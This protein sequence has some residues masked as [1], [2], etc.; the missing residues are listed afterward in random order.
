MES[1]GK[2][3]SEL[4]NTH[5][6]K[7]P[8]KGKPAADQWTVLSAIVMEHSGK[9]TVVTM[10]TGT[11]CVGE[12]QKSPT[13]V[14]D[15]HGEVL[16]LRLFRLF[17]LEDMMRCL[18]SE[19]GICLE[20][21]SGRQFV[22][23]EGVSFHFY[24]SHVMCGD[25]TISQTVPSSAEDKKCP[26]S[27]T[28]SLCP[29]PDNQS[30]F[31]PPDNQS[32]CPPPD[33]QSVCDKKRPSSPSYT[34]QTKHV[35]LDTTSRTGAKCLLLDNLQSETLR[36]RSWGKTS[37][38]RTKPGRG[39]VCLSLS[40]S[41]KL[42]KRQFL[43]LQGG[44]LS[45]FLRCP[46][47]FSTF[48]IGGDFCVD[49]VKRALFDRIPDSTVVQPPIFKVEDIFV[50]SVNNI[51]SN[52]KDKDILSSSSSIL[53]IKRGEDCQHWASVK[54]KVQGAT[55]SSS[56]TKTMLPVCRTAM[57]GKALFV[58]SLLDNEYR[59][60]SSG[61]AC[62]VSF[63]DSFISNKGDNFG[64][65]YQLFKS[66]SWVMAME[67]WEA[68]IIS[69]TILL[70][71]TVV[72]GFVPRALKV[73][74]N[75]KYISIANCVA[76]GV[77]MGTSLLHLLPEVMEDVTEGLKQNDIDTD[78]PIATLTVGLG[79]L[80][81]VFVEMLAH[82]IQDWMATRDEVRTVA[83]NANPTPEQEEMHIP[84]SFV[85]DE[86]NIFDSMERV[87]RF[88]RA[89]SRGKLENRNRVKTARKYSDPEKKPLLN[90]S[91]QNARRGANL[92]VNPEE[93]AGNSHGHSHG[94]SH[95]HDGHT[96]HAHGHGHGPGHAHDH[97]P[98][99][100]FKGFGSIL[101][102]F[103]L[104]V[105]SILEGM[106]VGSEK[107]WLMVFTLTGALSLHKALLAFALGCKIVEESQSL[108]THIRSVAF[109]ACSSP[110]GVAIGV[111]VELSHSDM[112]VKTLVEGLIQAI[113]T[114]TFLYIAFVEIVTP[115]L[116][117]PD[118]PPLLKVL[119]LA[120]GYAVM[121]GVQFIP[122]GDEKIVPN[123]TSLVTFGVSEHLTPLP[124]D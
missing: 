103:A 39:P 32:L 83:C 7:L 118:L 78:Y 124:V 6:N 82:T 59:D 10:A 45:R 116:N 79:F 62:S 5:Y 55:K 95:S 36:D 96:H 21:C 54:G 69:L 72:F 38:L 40:C 56:P 20:K 58:D 97:G 4:C 74:G 111:G 102:L 80:L 112:A 22:V 18:R 14:S 48:S 117:K 68:K 52:C 51:R 75:E 34:P 84:D 99:T 91:V 37:V 71:L 108:Q 122:E 77:L 113:A 8:K 13:I 16:C 64:V 89:S 28:Q 15:S 110:I 123:V 53:W 11:K 1:Q 76:G 105:H 50:N 85:E 121:C 66:K 114:G 35:K 107:D 26:L 60:S 44:L 57:L 94:S 25:A 33:N 30:L 47:R 98:P 93:S 119:F 24:S 17:L 100:E 61:H 2:T 120:L 49:S 65:H 90:N 88:T 19:R 92:Y 42:M 101:L 63:P 106:A 109:F 70:I 23:R 9:Y 29:S 104:S 27:D 3:I 115:E 81:I 87:R 67:S 31:P 43:G 73:A 12:N 86:I 41:D 46:I